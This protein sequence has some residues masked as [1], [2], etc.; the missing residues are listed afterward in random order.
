MGRRSRW[1]GR[2]MSQNDNVSETVGVPPD[3]AADV[4]TTKLM[5]DAA[6]P[7]PARVNIATNGLRPA[8]ISR[9]GV[10]AMMTTSAAT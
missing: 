1:H 9:H 10:T 4:S 5:T 7:R 2:G 3:D 8:S 6:I